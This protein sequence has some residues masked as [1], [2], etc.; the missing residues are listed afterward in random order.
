MIN[1]TPNKIDQSP[2]EFG[3]GLALG[4][5]E[6]TD[7]IRQRIYEYEIQLTEKEMDNME[8]SFML[9]YLTSLIATIA[10]SEDIPEKLKKRVIACFEQEFVKKL[11][12][13]KES[14]FIT[15][16]KHKINTWSQQFIEF[17]IEIKFV[18]DSPSAT[19]TLKPGQLLLKS[20]FGNL[21][22]NEAAKFNDVFLISTLTYD[23]YIEV[24][25][26]DEYVNDVLTSYKVVD[27]H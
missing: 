1:R 10:S 14:K 5:S 26:V 12:G 23:F 27:N 8:Q 2:E 4:L 21:S 25:I 7:N 9:V 19:S 16:L 24:H 17:I 18:I 3:Q 20:A 13:K 15:D 11:M 22:V 6:I